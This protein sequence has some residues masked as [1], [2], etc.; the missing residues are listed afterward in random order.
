[1]S[2]PTQTISGVPVSGVITLTLPGS[3][4]AGALL[5]LQLSYYQPSSVTVVAAPVDSVRGTMTLASQP[6]GVSP[7]VGDLMGEGIWYIQNAA[8]G[9]CT[10]TV[11]IGGTSPT[12]HAVLSEWP[13]MA[14]SSVF[15][16]NQQGSSGS[17]S[18]TQSRVSGTP[19]NSTGIGDLILAG[20]CIASSTGV[21]NAA[22]TDPPAGFTSQ[23]YAGNTSTD[24]AS[25]FA[26]KIATAA[27]AP[28]TSW[29][30]TDPSTVS[31]FGIIAFFKSNGVLPPSTDYQDSSSRRNRPGRG[32]Y[33]LG[34]YFRPDY[35]PFNITNQTY[36]VSVSEA[37]SAADALTTLENMI[38]AL[39][40]AGS[41]SD[42]STGL[43]STVQSL[44]ESGTAADTVIAGLLFASALTESGT[45]ADAIANLVTWL[46]ALT[47][48]GTG[49]DALSTLLTALGSV[50][51]AASAADAVSQGATSY[52]DNLPETLAAVDALTNFLNI[53]STL[54]DAGSAGDATD[55]GAN[56]SNAVTDSGA[57][58]DS[59][60]MQYGAGGTTADAASAADALATLMQMLNTIGE[61]LSAADALSATGGAANSTGAGRPKK[62]RGRYD[63]F[64]RL[65]VEPR[66]H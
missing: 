1:M 8:G 38:N 62:R 14:T 58:S 13:G 55:P 24:V 49:S 29:A 59:S 34:A 28:S 19:V 20:V 12:A 45:A 54:S 56:L 65:I 6:A 40:E 37:G 5:T 3:V 9:S 21:T 18:T 64:G 41:A 15:V 17:N 52:T 42:S 10:V 51:E 44:T 22:I 4:A 63:E 48:A 35:T 53:V 27:S 32:P 61:A 23:L 50:T 33:S 47:E 11:N 30:W 60:S 57:A 7:F 46:N 25:E 43:I 39:T 16:T 36:T 31:S 66:R 2:G 26:Y